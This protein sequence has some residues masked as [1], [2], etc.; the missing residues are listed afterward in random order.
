MKNLVLACVVGSAMTLSPLA[1]SGASVDESALAIC[2]KIIT[3]KLGVAHYTTFDKEVGILKQ[4]D[5][6]KHY[7]MNVSYKSPDMAEPKAFRSVCDGN[8]FKAT[9]AS[10]D[11]GAWS[12]NTAYSLSQQVADSGF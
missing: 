6:S 9:V 3:N 10:V 2:A 4:E 8:G 1:Y 7:L 5:G 12:F 11:E